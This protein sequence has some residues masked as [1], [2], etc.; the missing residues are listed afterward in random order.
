MRPRREEP[1]N[2]RIILGCHAVTMGAWKSLFD[3]LSVDPNKQ[4]LSCDV[5]SMR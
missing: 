4:L 2:F 1:I 5:V 3:V